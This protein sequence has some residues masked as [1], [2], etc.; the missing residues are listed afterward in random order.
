MKNIKLFIVLALVLPIISQQ[1][2]AQKRVLLKYNVKQGETFVSHQVTNQDINMQAQGQTISMNQVITKDIST[3]VSK[4]TPN[5]IKT[6]NTVDKMLMKQTM[7]GQELNYDSS[8]PSTYASGR[9]KLVGDALNKIIKK[10]YGIT[11]DHF[12]NVSSYDLSALLKDNNKVS[13]NIKS[14]N[15]YVI[16]PGHKVK[17]GDSWEADIKPMKMDKMDIHIKYTLK[18]LSGKK[19]TIGLE[20]TLTASKVAAQSMNLSGTQSGEVVVDTK[21]GWTMSSHMTQDIKMKIEK[22]GMEIPMDI[23]STINSTTTEKK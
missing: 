2:N 7:F 17:V 1:A 14:G 15:N 22:N 11:M 20:G 18:K 5:E 8:D 21:T 10:P 23:S 19:A 3:K 9:G 16:F 4:V 13:G 6:T 12:G